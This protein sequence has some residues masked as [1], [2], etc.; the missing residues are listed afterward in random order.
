[1][2]DPLQFFLSEM[3]REVRQFPE[4]GQQPFLWALHEGQRSALV[5]AKHG[6][7]LD[8]AL[9][10]LELDGQLLLRA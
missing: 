3:A 6:L 2:I 5:K 7:L 8:A 10:L 1:M 9:H 4:P